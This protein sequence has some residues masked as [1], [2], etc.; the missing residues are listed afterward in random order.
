MKKI[1]LIGGIGPAS[2]IDYY[3]EINRLYH[4][5]FGLDDYPEL[6]IDS[7]KMNTIVA[8]L[9]KGNIKEIQK[10]LSKSVNSLQAAG[11]EIVAICSNT[12]HTVLNKINE[13]FSLPLINIVDAVVDTIKQGNFHN[14]LIL[15]TV[16]T[17][18][19]RMYEQALHACN[20]QS[21]TPSYI[22]QKIIGSIIFPNLEN[23]IIL[24]EEKEAIIALAEKYIQRY[25]IDGVLLGCT[26]LPLIIKDG[27]LSV[28]AL[29]STIIHSAAIYN[30]AK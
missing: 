25:N 13:P 23:G 27:D 14:I 28:P 6:V 16:T 5:D 10:I 19:S 21:V 30:K 17:M 3:W 7:I 4:A 1:G 29:N 12:P 11:A 18:S 15:G 26:E 24:Q 20:I 8:A 9:D 2:T 22:D